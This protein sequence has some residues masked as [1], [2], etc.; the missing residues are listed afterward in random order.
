MEA[1]A[2]LLGD[3]LETVREHYSKWDRRRQAR[4]ESHLTDFWSNDKLTN[5]LSA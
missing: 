1:I 4:L 2:E 5:S 3:K